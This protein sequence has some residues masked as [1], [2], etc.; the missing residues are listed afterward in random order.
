MD[1]NGS[2]RLVDALRNH[3]VTQ[4]K[5]YITPALGP[6]IFS[7]A[8]NTRLYLSDRVAADSDGAVL[9]AVRTRR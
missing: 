7:R 3:L 4:N 9:L 6:F 8:M 1:P 5:G 2:E